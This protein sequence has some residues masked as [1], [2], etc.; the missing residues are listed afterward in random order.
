MPTQLRRLAKIQLGTNILFVIAIWCVL[1]DIIQVKTNTLHAFLIMIT[2]Y[3]LS[4]VPTNKNNKTERKLAYLLQSI[5]YI[6]I[7]FTLLVIMNH[8]FDWSIT[9]FDS[10]YTGMGR[11]ETAN[12]LFLAFAS[13]AN[14][15]ARYLL[16]SKKEEMVRIIDLRTEANEQIDEIKAD[17]EKQIQSYK[18]EIERLEKSSRDK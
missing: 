2:I 10:I 9:V 16:H 7:L 18:Q 13:I 8:V 6:I 1:F 12:Y 17:Y 11:L 15:I 5:S 4:V 14:T 3:A